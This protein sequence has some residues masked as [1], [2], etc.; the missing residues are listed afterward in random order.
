MK[1]EG[2]NNNTHISN[3]EQVGGRKNQKNVA[4]WD[5]KKIAKTDLEEYGMLFN[6]KLVAYG[7]IGEVDEHVGQVRVWKRSELNASS[8]FPDA[9]LMFVSEGLMYVTFMIDS[10]K[11]CINSTQAAAQA[12]AE[13]TKPA[14][15]GSSG[16]TWNFRKPKP[17]EARPKPRPSLVATTY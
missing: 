6:L 14:I 3:Q 4:Y 17:S 12:R 8:S 5:E 11:F 2:S 16:L 7:S 15:T 9:R 13:P 1:A 10:S